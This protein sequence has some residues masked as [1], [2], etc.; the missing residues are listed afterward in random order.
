[1]LSRRAPL[2]LDH[3]KVTKTLFDLGA[4]FFFWEYLGAE[5]K[6]VPSVCTDPKF[7][8]R[9]VDPKQRKGMQI[10]PRS[11]STEVGGGEKNFATSWIIQ[12]QYLLLITE[13]WSPIYVQVYSYSGLQYTQ[14]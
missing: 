1:M 10:M 14:A 6:S 5:I 4:D 13:N 3:S 9:N 11:N 8:W 7:R 12:N 2:I